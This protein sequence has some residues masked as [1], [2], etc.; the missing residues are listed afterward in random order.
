MPSCFSCKRSPAPNF[1]LTASDAADLCIE[2]VEMTDLGLFGWSSMDDY[3]LSNSPATYERV[4][5][6]VQR[7]GRTP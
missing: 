6:A 4:V 7:Y 2:R 5:E 3:N 1:A